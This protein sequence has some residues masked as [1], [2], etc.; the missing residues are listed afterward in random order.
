MT[1]KI[2]GFNFVLL[3]GSS[4]FT[5]SFNKIFA[6]IIGECLLFEVRPKIFSFRLI[7]DADKSPSEE[8]VGWGFF[9][10]NVNF[11][12]ALDVKLIS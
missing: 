12:E 10:L 8:F 11:R 2:V 4:N 5:K 9:I 1:K 7:I 6:L 3:F